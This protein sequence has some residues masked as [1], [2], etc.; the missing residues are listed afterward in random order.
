MGTTLLRRLAKL[1]QKAPGGCPKLSHLAVIRACGK[2]QL[3]ELAAE[4]HVSLE[5]LKNWSYDLV[6]HERFTGYINW[7]DGMLYSAEAE[8]LHKLGRCPQCNGEMSLVGKGTIVCQY[9]GAEV[10]L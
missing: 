7:D 1:F 3:D 9:Y 10:F 4:M 6:R 5:M 2:I 8:Q